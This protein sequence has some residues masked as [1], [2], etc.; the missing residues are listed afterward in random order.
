M[1]NMLYYCT[2]LIN[3]FTCPSS[4]S[5]SYLSFLSGTGM[6]VRWYVCDTKGRESDE[7]KNGERLVLISHFA[8]IRILSLLLPQ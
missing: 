1:Q 8:E 4:K 2:G 5:E 3:W 7:L 6:S